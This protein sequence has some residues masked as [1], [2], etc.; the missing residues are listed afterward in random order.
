TIDRVVAIKTLALTQEF[1][2]EGMKDA[3]ER[4]FHEAAAAGRLNHP[5]IVTIYDAGEEHDLS[6]IAMEYVEGKPLSDFCKPKKLLPI[7]KVL[8]IIVRTADALGYAHDQDVVHRDIKPA[9]LM[10][11]T[12]SGKVMVTDFGIARITSNSRTKTGVILGT[13]SF[14]SPEQMSGQKVDG[15]SDL[16]SLAS[17]MFVLLTGQRPFDGE[18]LAVLSHQIINEKQLDICK[19]RA[20]IPTSVRNIIDKALQKD[21]D[22]RYSSGVSM[23]RA[24]Q[25]CLK[26]LQE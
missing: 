13:P 11:N 4:F 9:N 2:E 19:I 20:D 21:P 16:F 24:V 26:G 18:S 17:S 23:K 7:E 22:K 25:R 8:E 3:S 6:Y 5:N 15:R 12:K 10:Y 1:D 14:M